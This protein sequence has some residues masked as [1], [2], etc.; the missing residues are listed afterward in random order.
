MSDEHAS[1]SQGL[2]DELSEWRGWL[3]E[4]GLD[5]GFTPDS[6][7]E[8][9]A[10]ADTAR[11][12]RNETRRMRDRVSAIEVDIDQFRSGWP[13]GSNPRN[14]AGYRGHAAARYVG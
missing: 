5:E 6:L 10:R 11:A 8:F 3:R 13:P 9:L 14:H 1:A 4:R 2:E 7:L 12:H